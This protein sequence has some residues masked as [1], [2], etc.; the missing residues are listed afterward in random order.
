MLCESSSVSRIPRSS[1]KTMDS[2]GSSLLGQKRSSKSSNIPLAPL[3]P[4]K[5]SHRQIMIAT[6][7]K[8][9]L[10]MVYMCLSKLWGQG[11]GPWRSLQQALPPGQ[12]STLNLHHIPAIT[13]PTWASEASPEVR[14]EKAT[15]AP[16]LK[17]KESV[18]I[19][20]K[21]QTTVAN[22]G[23]NF[24]QTMAAKLSRKRQDSAWPESIVE[25][26]IQLIGL[27]AESTLL[28]EQSCTTS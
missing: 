13:S 21:I 12:K 3:I 24:L 4:A 23:S 1:S 18:R 7:N 8:S 15:G 10:I 26:N 27:I 20:D 17:R 28:Y 19:R 2:R 22:R 16:A 14:D 5:L 9:V 11:V 25:V 6:L